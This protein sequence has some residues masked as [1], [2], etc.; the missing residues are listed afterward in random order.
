MQ[1]ELITFGPVHLDIQ[2]V[3]LSLAFWCDVV[4]LRFL[5]ATDGVA[6]LGIDTVPLVILRE[7]AKRPVQRGYSGLYHLAIQLPT[8]PEFA[9]VV[10]RLRALRCA[11][12]VQDHVIAKSIYLRDPDGVALEV[13]FETPERVRSFRW[14]EGSP[15]ALVIDSQGRRRTGIEPLDIEEV[16]AV[17]PDHDIIRPLPSGTVVGHLHFQVADI[18]ASYAFYREKLGFLPGM[19]APWAG[20]GDLGAGGPVAHRI[21]L[22][23]WRGAGAPP[24][25]MGVAGLHSFTLRFASTQHLNDAVTSIGNAEPRGNEYVARDPDGNVLVMSSESE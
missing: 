3:Q 12:G 21:A 9:R 6:A 7:S 20:Y 2:D 1:S 24:R 16:L 18:G 10:A 15:S 17:L 25:P 22:N 13:T 11:F 4:G 19:Y 23:T 5:D 14:Y 8:E